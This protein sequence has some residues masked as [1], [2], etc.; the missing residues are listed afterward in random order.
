MSVIESCFIVGE[1]AVDKL[2]C[3]LLDDGGDEVGVI[4]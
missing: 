2:L 3:A 4:Y 1:F